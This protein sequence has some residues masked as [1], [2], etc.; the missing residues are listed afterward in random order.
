M[1]SPHVDRPRGEC[2]SCR[3]LQFIR[4][5]GTVHGHP[6]W[7]R[8]RCPGS[9]LTPAEG[10]PPFAVELVDRLEQ[11]PTHNVNG[12]AMVL[13]EDLRAVIDGVLAPAGGTR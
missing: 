2:R 4:R 8:N 13:A 3:T 5:D 6:A 12:R 10:P 9:G 1:A 7:G 11:L